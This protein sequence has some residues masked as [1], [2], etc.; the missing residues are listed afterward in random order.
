MPV[1]CD[2][3]G[4]SQGFQQIIATFYLDVSVVYINIYSLI[5]KLLIRYTSQ[6]L[7]N[8]PNFM[9]RGFSVKQKT[10][11]SISYM[12]NEFRGHPAISYGR[13]LIV[14]TGLSTVGPY[15]FNVTLIASPEMPNGRT[16]SCPDRTKASACVMTSRRSLGRILTTHGQ[17]E[18]INAYCWWNH[19]GFNYSYDP[20]I[21]CPAQLAHNSG[22]VKWNRILNPFTAV[23]DYTIKLKHKEDGYIRFWLFRTHWLVRM[24]EINWNMLGWNWVF[25]NI[26]WKFRSWAIRYVWVLLQ[27]HMLC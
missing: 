18:A 6:P 19:S 15:R 9:S 23:Y 13:V 4:L 16:G 20:E 17:C 24:V 1:S 26:G 10:L 27:P 21:K 5:D 2:Q 8:E 12:T 11:W 22:L 25:R 7:H 3:A 14:N